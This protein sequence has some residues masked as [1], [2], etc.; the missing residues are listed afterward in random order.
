ML[1][2]I[3]YLNSLS[4]TNE[5]IIE[6]F[7]NIPRKIFIP[8]AYRSLADID[9]PLPIGCGQT[10]SQPSLVAF[11]TEKLEVKKEHNILEI[12]TGTGFQTA[13]LASLCK[14]IYTIE[15]ID[16]LIKKAKNNIT[17]LNIKNVH[18]IQGDGH[19]GYSTA[20]PY[21]R[22]MVTAAAK[23][24]P[25]I[26]LD[27]LLPGGKMIIPIGRPGEDQLLQVITKSESEKI[28]IEQSLLVRF[29]PMVNSNKI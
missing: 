25:K 23:Q 8:I 15:I 13:I 19:F 21:H 2:N 9:K 10:I 14:N 22:I 3:S 17:T 28:I 12:G 16:S 20:A 27:Q 4:I 5:R 6:I 7:H 29:V 24:I 1:K 18:F 26:L 11:M